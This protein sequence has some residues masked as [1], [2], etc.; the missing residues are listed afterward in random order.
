MHQERK[1]LSEKTKNVPIRAGNT[2]L[3]IHKANAAD[4]IPIVLNEIKPKRDTAT[5]PL[6]LISVMA[7]VGIIEIISNMIIV[8]VIA[9]R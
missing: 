5:D 9:S 4:S 2:R 7:I 8:K 1:N 3:I 6:T